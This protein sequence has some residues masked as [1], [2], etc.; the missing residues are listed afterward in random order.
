M[1]RWELAQRLGL[2]FA[3]DSLLYPLYTETVRTILLT[4]VFA[5]WKNR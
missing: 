2:F 4:I 3:V 1:N 5:T